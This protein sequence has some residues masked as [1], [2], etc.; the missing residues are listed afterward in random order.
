MTKKQRD[1]RAKEVSRAIEII[2]SSIESHLC[3]TYGAVY[4][5]KKETNAFH[6]KCVREYIE[7]LATLSKMF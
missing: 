5:K 1:A 6:K 4:E 2:S 3:Y 7:V